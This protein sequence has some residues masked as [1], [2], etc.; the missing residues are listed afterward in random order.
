MME[1]IE[2]LIESVARTLDHPSL[3]MGGASQ[4]SKRKAKAIL[5]QL[6]IETL[7]DENARLREALVLASNRLQRCAVD[8]DTGTLRFI[9]TCEWADE[10]RETSNR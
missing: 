8:Y 5:E 4:Q 2:V 3:Y 1:P 6:G 7:L 9:E 10:A